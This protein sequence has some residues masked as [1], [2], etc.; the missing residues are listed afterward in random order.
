MP[1]DTITKRIKTK[2]EITDSELLDALKNSMTPIF[3]HFEEEIAKSGGK[4][5]HIEVTAQAGKVKLNYGFTDIDPTNATAQT[6]RKRHCHHSGYYG[7]DIK[8]DPTADCK[9]ESIENIIIKK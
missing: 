2:R 4:V 1:K 5:L 7:G 3:T 6:Y 8:N 9:W